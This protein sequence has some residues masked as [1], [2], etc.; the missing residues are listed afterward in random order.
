MPLAVHRT[1][2]VAVAS[3]F[4]SIARRNTLSPSVR[5]PVDQLTPSAKSARIQPP[6]S[7]KPSPCR[8]HRLSQ[9][10]SPPASAAVD[11]SALAAAFECLQDTARALDSGAHC[12]LLQELGVTCAADVADIDEA[13][14]LSIKALLKPAAAASFVKSV[15]FEPHACMNSCFSYLLNATKHADPAAMCS[16]ILQLGLS[17]PHELQHLDDAQLRGIVALLKPV[18][19][20]VF[21]LRMRFVKRT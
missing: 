16:L 3:A 8:H 1:C 19:A 13:S 5:R 12:N 2:S 7:L 4:T 15:G 20:K 21:V 9:A 10:Q 17:Q 6:Y 18:A 14:V 11:H